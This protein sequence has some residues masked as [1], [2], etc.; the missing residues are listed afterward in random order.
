MNKRFL[1]CYTD[2]C[3]NYQYP[4]FVMSDDSIDGI[5]TELDAVKNAGNGGILLECEG[6]SGFCSEKW[7]HDF[8]FALAE[9]KKRGMKIWLQD[10]VQFPSGYANYSLREKYPHLQ[11]KCLVM[12]NM[13]IVGPIKG[14][15]ILVEKFLEDED[16]LFAVIACKRGDY[17]NRPLGEDAV[18]LTNNIKD[19]L[20]FWDVP[21]GMWRVYIIFYSFRNSGIYRFY[22]DMLNPESC[23]L[24][25]DEVYN[26]QY[27]HFKEYFGNTLEAFW[28][29][30]PGFG[31]CATYDFCH[32]LGTDSVNVP[33]R[34][35]FIKILAEKMGW[36]EEKMLLALPAFWQDIGIE[37][38]ALRNCYMDL[39]TQLFSDNFT[40]RLS[41]WCHEHGIY[42]YGH[43]IEDDDA[44]M[45]FGCGPGHFFRAQ[46]WQ[47]ASGFDLVLQ[48]LQPGNISM[49]YVGFG[50]QKYTDPQFYMYA[51]GKLGSS[52][53]HLTPHMN[54][55]AIC[56]C[57]GAHGWAGGVPFGKYNYDTMLVGGA[58]KFV[59]G[60]YNSSKTWSRFPPAN[61]ENGENLQYGF[62]K[63]LVQY[64]N[65]LC[66]LLSG[67]VHKAN[68]L[69]YYPAE[70]DWCGNVQSTGSLVAPLA[71]AHIDCDFA[72]WDM[73]KGDDLTIQDNKLCICREKFDA[74]VI[75]RCDYLPL[76]LLQYFDSLAQIVPVVFADKYP[77]DVATRQ[78]FVPEYAQCIPTDQIPQ[79]FIQQGF[80]DYVLEGN[81]HLM[82]IHI[83]HTGT[84][85]YFFFNNSTT[86][87]IDAD[88]TFP[89]RGNYV[90][91]DAW[92]NSGVE[93]NTADGK[94][95]IALFP[96]ATIVVSFGAVSPEKQSKLLA[97]DVHK[98]CWS[99]LDENTVFSVEKKSTLNSEWNQLPDITAKELHNFAYDDTRFCAN[100]RYTAK[101]TADE[102]PTHIDLGMVGEMASLK[103]NGVDC[104]EYVN[105]PFIY[106]VS[107][108]WQDGEN[109]IE[110]FVATNIVYSRRDQFSKLLPLLPVG[111]L[112]PIS[113]GR[114]H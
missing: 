1:D 40:K 43:I 83:S 16:K 55:V 58:N 47:D 29:D 33:W 20:V 34:A 26:Y 108:A 80:V 30:E 25:I 6:Y 97:E 42:Y 98:V 75:P 113:L 72:P 35:D 109:T 22:L 95:H 82:H 37:T 17:S 3:P 49:P 84:E 53:G 38:L 79:W 14:A 64:T 27:E 92:D 32:K 70:G 78:N 11:R 21:E 19:G 62:Q 9:A 61:Y 100:L 106:D 77:A 67:G 18:D 23:Q 50:A 56:E 8:G 39:V 105:S 54:G 99:P 28:T 87:S 15:A 68:A 90:L 63:S 110:I 44:H 74:L 96:R 104:G 24:M 73:L 59:L 48:Q 60:L 31:N 85:T 69:I 12:E 86:E 13:D 51:L 94:V 36:S 107:E 7:V 57:G 91:Y 103:V 81:E 89:Y 102:K 71:Q 66:H 112:G 93:R 65:R 5:V 101:I 45:R 41:E 76:E 10:D 4:F 52:G 111:L 88:I 114:K 2:S 46:K